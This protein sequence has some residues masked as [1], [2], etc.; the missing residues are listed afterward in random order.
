MVEVFG[1]LDGKRG[2][3]SHHQRKSFY[4][5]SCTEADEDH[6]DVLSVQLVYS[7]NF[8]L[9]VEQDPYENLR[10]QAGVQS[11][12][13]SWKLL[14]NESFHTPEATLTHSAESSME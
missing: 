10:I 8:E 12:G 2:T 9:T 1:E 11:L 6:G 3:S 14:A 5:S 13:F 4:G 7:G